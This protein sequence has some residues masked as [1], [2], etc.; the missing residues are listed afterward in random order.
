MNLAH[1]RGHRPLLSAADRPR[2]HPLLACAQ[3]LRCVPPPSLTT[4]IAPRR[5]RQLQLPLVRQ[6][7]EMPR[8]DELGPAVPP[9]LLPRSARAG[10]DRGARRSPPAV[11]EAAQIPLPRSDHAAGQ[12]ARQAAPEAATGRREEDGPPALRHPSPELAASRAGATAR[13]KD[14]AS[15]RRPLEIEE[16]PGVRGRDPSV[17][18]AAMGSD[19]D[20]ARESRRAPIKD[21]LLNGRLGNAPR[22][23]SSRRS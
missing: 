9:L 10:R 2:R 13:R 14:H 12:D 17:D 11:A 3:R 8:L 16:R 1:A 5:R 20:A 23:S 15:P 18:S 19:G 4:T 6:R 21:R 7:K 22:Q